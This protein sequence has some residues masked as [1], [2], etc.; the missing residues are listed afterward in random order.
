MDAASLELAIRVISATG[1]PFSLRTQYGANLRRANLRTI[2]KQANEYMSGLWLLLLA[3]WGEFKTLALIDF[4][5]AGR[6]NQSNTNGGH[7]ANHSDQPND[8]IRS[9]AFI[10][11][12]IKI[13]QAK[14]RQSSKENETK[15]RREKIDFV[16]RIIASL[17]AIIGVPVLV[18]QSSANLRQAG[19][20]ERQL[21]EMRTESL[22]QDRPWLAIYHVS[23]ATN[24]ANNPPGTV[25][26]PEVRNVGR[27]P[28]LNVVMSFTLTHKIELV[29]KSDYYD[30]NDIQ[31]FNF[32]GPDDTKYFDIGEIDTIDNS[33]NH[34]LPFYIFGTIWYDDVFGG[35]HW[36]R[37]GYEVTQGP[38][39]LVFSDFTGRNTCDE[40]EK[41]K[42]P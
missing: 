10:N 41:V 13:P 37:W 12:P 9:K 11:L 22:I 42:K 25:L 34:V 31:I 29:T 36:T 39:N 5:K 6:G 23:V 35:K 3:V 30:T 27:T 32:F 18:M 40:A 4:L 17:A 21:T 26:I 2:T 28:A 15:A 7:R 33:T 19:A 20:A 8:Q 14:D 16:L 1:L 24:F 38:T